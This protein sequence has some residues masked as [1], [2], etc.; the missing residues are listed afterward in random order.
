MLNQ[1]ELNTIYK[2]INR[3]ET[4]LLKCLDDIEEGTI[5]N[6][7]ILNAN[8]SK[9]DLYRVDYKLEIKFTVD[10]DK[11]II[12]DWFGRCIRCN[13]FDLV[14]FFNYDELTYN[15]NGCCKFIKQIGY[16]M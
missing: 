9:V 14:D 7:K 11:Y 4:L 13:A 12:K 8:K 1:K 5:S 2:L 10:N 3:D 16:Y 15:K 6:I